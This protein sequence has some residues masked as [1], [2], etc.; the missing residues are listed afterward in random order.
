MEAERARGDGEVRCER[1]MVGRVMNESRL[2]ETDAFFDRG[3]RENG[4]S[5]TPPLE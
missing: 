2:S 1:Q 4:Y 3:W 5:G